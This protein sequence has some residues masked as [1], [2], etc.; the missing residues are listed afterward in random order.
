MPQKI[1]QQRLDW[2]KNQIERLGIRF[3]VAD[4]AEKTGFDQGNISSYLKGKKP[5]SDNFL[6]KF[7][8]AYGIKDESEEDG[9]TR[10]ILLTLAEAFK[11]QT[12]ILRD[13]R[14]EMARESTQAIVKEIVEKTDANS[15]EILAGVRSL[16]KRQKQAIADV[17]RDLAELKSH[18][19]Q[20]PDSGRNLRRTDG[21]GKKRGIQ[22]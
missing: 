9:T 10:Q 20:N 3:P 21:E 22:P 2:F 6:T 13:M 4:I 15:I 17:R 14:K 8:E 5:V 7:R 1:D 12:E 18:V 19:D 11:A 16:S